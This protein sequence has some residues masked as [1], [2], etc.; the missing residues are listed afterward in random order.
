MSKRRWQDNI[1]MD[2]KKQNGKVWTGLGQ[3]QVTGSCLNHHIMWTFRWRPVVTD[4]PFHA[5]Q[6]TLHLFML[7]FLKEWIENTRDVLCNV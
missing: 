5:T 7:G 4:W 3:G 1:K 6:V 2:L